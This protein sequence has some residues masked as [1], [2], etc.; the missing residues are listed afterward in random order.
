MTKKPT[1]KELERRVK[2]FEKEALKDNPWETFKEARQKLPSLLENIPSFIT[3]TD[4]KGTIQYINKVVSGLTK[5]EVIG[6]NIFD[7][8]PS[9]QNEILKNTLKEV[10]QSEKSGNFQLEALGPDSGT[11]W[12]EIHFAPVKQ[13][14]RVIAVTFD[15]IDITDRKYAEEE[16]KK[17]EE[18]YR[19]LVESHNSPIVLLDKEGIFLAVNTSGAANLGLSPSDMIGKPL[20]RLFPKEADALLERHRQIIA[21]GKGRTFEDVHDFPDG[22]RWYLA[23]VLPARD[24]NGKIYGVIVIS[25]DITARK[26]MEEKLQVKEEYYR[27]LIENSADGISV[28]DANG[29]VTYTGASFKHV[30]GYDVI[31]QDEPT[32]TD[33]V[34]PDDIP[35]LVDAFAALRDNPGKKTRVEVRIRDKGSNWLIVEAIGHNLLDNPSVA[36]IVVNF[37]DIT[38]RKKA[39]EALRKSEEDYRLHTENSMDGIYQIDSSGN[40]IFVNKALSKISGYEK[41]NLIGTYLGNFI[42]KKDL[43]KAR[44]LFDELQA[45]RSVQSEISCLHKR[46]HELIICFNAVPTIKNGKMLSVT[47]TMRNITDSKRLEEQLRQSHKM[48]SIGTLAGG[49]AHDFNNTLAA[50]LSYAELSLF[51]NEGNNVLRSN[52][53]QIVL[54]VNHGKNLVKQILAFAR[55]TNQGRKPLDIRLII[56]EIHKFLKVTLPTSIELR[57][58]IQVKSGTI[59]ADPTQIK[60]VLMNLCSNAAYA[61]RE[62]NGLLEINLTKKTLNPKDIVTYPELKPG[63]YLKLTIRDTGNGINQENIERIFDPFFTTKGPGEGTGMGLSVVHG[64][65]KNHGGS[66]RVKSKSG[67]G[68]TFQILLPE[69]EEKVAT[70]TDIFKPVSKTAKGAH[71]LFVDDEKA[72]V[73]A[74]KQMLEHLGYKVTAHTSS[75]EALKAFS[76]QPDEIDLVISDMAMPDMTGLDLSK[77]LLKLRPNLPIIV[78]T[79]YSERLS[80]KKATETGI[81]EM[82]MKPLSANEL[83]DSIDKILALE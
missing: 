20:S 50:I 10:F 57:H 64:I 46:G 36:G 79:G 77:K 8:I 76:E 60:Q 25:Q 14:G 43:P 12:Y 81:R 44:G 3:I 54:S 19:L 71:I 1:Y 37:R 27:A 49:I 4:R 6:K 48:E 78:C 58:N 9:G 34:H 40:F 61:M 33:N 63:T 7:F 53:D 51:Q 5:D 16:L 28:L 18:K 13:D 68:S 74:G 24:G 15:G 55:P 56:A 41:E 42:T 82:L 66:I 80:P 17:S 31:E 47:G 26:Q 73:R 52:L 35:R 65:V 72:L 70:I 2:E 11:S 39:E 67:K 21:S 29:R 30:L 38:E 22:K 83:I 45:G 59:I 23:N 32:F 69:A 75:I 62:K